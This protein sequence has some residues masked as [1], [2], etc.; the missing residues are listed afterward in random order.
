[1]GIGKVNP[2][3]N[4][5]ASAAAKTSDDS[6]VKTA[7]NV[8]EADKLYKD[9]QVLT[10]L[11]AS[12]GS[13][14]K[15]DKVHSPDMMKEFGHILRKYGV[16]TATG[17]NVAAISTDKKNIVIN[18]D[19]K[20][21]KQYL[22]NKH[23]FKNYK[24]HVIG[25]GVAFAGIALGFTSSFG[26]GLGLIGLGAL[27]GALFGTK[28][29]DRTDLG[30]KLYEKFFNQKKDQKYNQ[31]SE[32]KEHFIKGLDD[33]THYT[34]ILLEKCPKTGKYKPRLI[35]ATTDL[36]SV[37]QRLGISDA[38]PYYNQYYIHKALNATDDKDL[39]SGIKKIMDALMGTATSRA[40][41]TGFSPDELKDQITNHNIKGIADWEV[42]IKRADSKWELRKTPLTVIT[43]K[44][45]DYKVHD[46]LARILAQLHA[47]AANIDDLD[48]AKDKAHFDTAIKDNQQK[49]H[50]MYKEA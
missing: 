12:L 24:S 17:N 3:T 44:N 8:D 1:M 10:D 30:L 2:N 21:T 19:G 16:E 32:S 20:K 9:N 33:G 6:T 29:E 26:A 28:K 18:L 49:I 25:A 23:S 13:F 39:A 45:F 40:F 34:Q 41:Y 7:T 35:T 42:P 11:N 5:A 38:E 37:A 46:D 31:V 27:C 47:G 48:H 43:P 36:R 4:A 50:D 15:F 22:F 14:K